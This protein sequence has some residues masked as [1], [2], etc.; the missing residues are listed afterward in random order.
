MQTDNFW[1]DKPEVCFANPERNGRAATKEGVRIR[2]NPVQENL[3]SAK[4]TP[5]IL[6]TMAKNAVANLF[7]SGA[8]WIIVF[9]LPPLLVRVLDKS[10]YGVWMLLLQVAAYVTVFDSGIQTA[11]ARFVARIEISQ[12]RLY[13]GRLLSSVGAV[14]VVSSLATVLLTALVSWQLTHLFSD[15]PPSIAHDS[16]EALLVIGISVALTLPFSV[17][18]GFFAGLQKNEINAFAVSLGKFTGALGTAWAAYTHKG[19]LAM[20]VWAGAG[21]LIQCLTYTLFWNREGNRSLLRFTWIDVSMIREF[22]VFCSAMLVSQFS[23][24]LISGLDMPIVVAFDFHSAAYY[25]VAAMLSSALIVPYGAIISTLMPVAAG[26]SARDTPQR[27]GEL[28]VKTTRFST[29]VLCLITVPLLLGMPLF[30]RIWV[31]SD[32][33]IHTLTL[34]EILVV[35][36]FTRLSML[37]YAMVGYA[38]GQLN[39]MLY[40]P[41]SESLVNLLCSLIAVRVIGAPGVAL[42]TLIGAIVSVS[43]HVFVSLPRTD[44]VLVSRKRL[45]GTGILKPALFALPILLV[46][47]ALTRW[48]SL[49]WFQLPLIMIA[50]LIL[51]LLYWNF[52]FNTGDREQLKGLIRH[53]FNLSG[54][55]FPVLRP[56]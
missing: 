16:R 15:I 3:D 47:L 39:R 46:T 20:S 27:M 9:F 34:A 50:E 52:S 35:A 14:L 44:C 41:I 56:E 2:M 48:I 10:T 25:A 23:G 24:I 17:V 18:A 45:A 49:P 38:A 53:G 30:L 4:S 43:V 37:P 13:M 1:K 36:Q 33:A 55:L 5:L 19:L 42:G 54:R 11:I 28:L 40:A 21:S 31:G 26:M 32:Y 12:D 7:R 6:V 22:L 8:S 29:V 51:L